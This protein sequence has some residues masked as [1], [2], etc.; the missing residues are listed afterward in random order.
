MSTN[1]LL[2]LHNH[3]S[4][5][6]PSG[7]VASGREQPKPRWRRTLSGK[8]CVVTGAS[9]GVGRAVAIELSRRGAIVLAT[10]RREPLLVGLAA[11]QIEIGMSQPILYTAGDITSNLFRQ[12]LIHTAIEQM[13]G[14]DI[15][16]AAAGSGAIGA[17]SHASPQTLQDIMDVDFFAPAELVRQSLPALACGRDSVA[18]LIGSILGYHA[19]PLH[20]EYCAAKSAL[21]SLVNTLRLEIA[22]AGIQ[23]LLASLGP[24]ETEFWDHLLTG[25]RPRWS[26]GYQWSA[27]KTAASI[28]T[29]IEHRR[30]EIVPGFGA[31][32]F[33]LGS[34]LFP[35]LINA[36]LKRRFQRDARA[37][38]NQPR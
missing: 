23:I 22:P 7:S 28:V 1:P 26:R 34:R 25:T 24:T 33:V 13:G 30:R 20:A 9:S 17:F 32:A 31:K 21:R 3:G 19:L 16:V 6:W 29:A 2:P 5:D 8:R 38:H 12:Q 11:E 4:G 36:I 27:K 35:S 18:V 37:L 14:I 10:A 15:L